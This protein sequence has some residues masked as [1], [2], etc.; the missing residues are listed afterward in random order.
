MGAIYFD[1]CLLYVVSGSASRWCRAEQTMLTGD[2]LLVSLIASDRTGKEDTPTTVPHACSFP[3]PVT[4]CIRYFMVHGRHRPMMGTRCRSAR[5][6]D[7]STSLSHLAEHPSDSRHFP[8]V[9]N[10]ATVFI[11]P[12][13]REEALAVESEAALFT[14]RGRR[15]TQ[16]THRAFPQPR[17]YGTRIIRLRYGGTAGASSRHRRQGEL[18]ALQS[19]LVQGEVLEGQVPLSARGDRGGS[20]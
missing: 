12:D 4:K 3:P 10:G 9:V 2:E 18:A 19:V 7:E 11:G 1:L 13:T 6:I 14:I 5:G 8:L 16:M 15:G 17:A 20:R